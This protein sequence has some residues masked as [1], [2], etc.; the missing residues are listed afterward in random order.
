MLTTLKQREL[1]PEN[2]RWAEK[3]ISDA[4]DMRARDAAT[5]PDTV[6]TAPPAAAHAAGIEPVTDFT[7]KLELECA[8]KED[9]IQSVVNVIATHAH[10]GSKGEGKIV[11]IDLLSVI[12]I[13]SGGRDEDVFAAAESVDLW[14][15]RLSKRN[16]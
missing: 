8:V 9:M 10:T 3:A 15:D 16:L 14:Y 13:R 5:R 1:F 12:R 6:E 11:V 2:L 7:P 4:E